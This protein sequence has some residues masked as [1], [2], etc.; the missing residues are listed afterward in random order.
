MIF[1]EKGIIHV[2]DAL[3]AMLAAGV[4][5]SSPSEATTNGCQTI[6]EDAKEPRE[7]SKRSAFP[8]GHQ[9]EGDVSRTA[10]FDGRLH[11]R[12]YSLGNKPRQPRL[13]VRRSGDAKADRQRREAGR[14]LAVRRAHDGEQ[15]NALKHSSGQAASAGPCPTG[16]H[17]QAPTHDL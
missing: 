17:A 7:L 8:T 3:A 9:G 12:D 11:N 14:R 15:A 16:A 1:G 10:G 5:A 13:S 6:P 2:P 4:L